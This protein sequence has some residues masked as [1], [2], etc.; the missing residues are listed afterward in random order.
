MFEQDRLLMRLQ[1]RVLSEPAIL[2]CF[3]TGSYGRRTHDPYSD[4]DVVLVFGGEREREVA[5]AGRREFVESLMPYV[6]AKS[7]DARHI[8]PFFHIALFANGAKADFRYET[9]EALKPSVWDRDIQLIK[10][11]DGWGKRFQVEAEK[12]SS[13][14]PRPTFT[15]RELVDLDNRF[16]IM[17]IDVYRVLLRGDYDK[18]YPVYLELLSFTIPLLL[19][20]LPS[21]DP[22][23]QSLSI[24]HYDH[25]TTA[26]TKHMRALMNAYLEARTAVIRRYNLTFMPDQIFETA[27]IKLISRGP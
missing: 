2:V 16:W 27:I 15:E 22:A 26:T 5:Y 1:Q 21:E 23:H 24:S 7:F 11:K 8:R 19:R 4:L 3:L 20:L 18:P 9:K 25:D 10:D 12:L 13:V 14:P 17:F 6:P